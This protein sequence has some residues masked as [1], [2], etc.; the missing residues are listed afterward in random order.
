MTVT[1][2]TAIE[3][4]AIMS[5]AIACLFLPAWLLAQSP[6]RPLDKPVAS[7]RLNAWRTSVQELPDGRVLVVDSLKRLIAL[8]SNLAFL[9]VV[10]DSIPTRNRP[11]WPTTA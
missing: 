2:G 3:G 9:K 6:V 4:P 5:R 1:T 8:D 11:P 7:V 10:V